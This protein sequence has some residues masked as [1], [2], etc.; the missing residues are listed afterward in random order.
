MNGFHFTLNEVQSDMPGDK[1]YVRLHGLATGELSFGPYPTQA[2]AFRQGCY[3]M[4][5]Y[6]LLLD[7]ATKSLSLEEVA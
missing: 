4:E 7:D 1:W 6:R 2:V 5:Q 3:W